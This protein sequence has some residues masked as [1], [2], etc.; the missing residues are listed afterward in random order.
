M[1]ELMRLY[2]TYLGPASHTLLDLGAAGTAWNNL[3]LQG[4]NS[5][6]VIDASTI[7]VTRLFATSIQTVSFAATNMTFNTRLIA[8]GTGFFSSILATS[9]VRF[10][11][12][13]SS[14][15]VTDGDLWNDTRQKTLFTYVNSAKQYIP[16]ILFSSTQIK[17]VSNNATEDSLVGSGIGTNL[18]PANFFTAGKTVRLT[19]SGFYSTQLIPINLNIRIRV[20]GAGGTGGVEVLTTGDQAPA[21][22]LSG[23]FWRTACDLMCQTSG[24]SGTIIGQSAWEHQSTATG[25]PVFWQ[26]VATTAAIVDT[27]TENRIQLSADWAAGVA[28]TDDIRC[29]NLIIESLN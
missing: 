18:I 29:T 7:M 15:T 5:S 4:T 14:S 6:S 20:G 21:G 17:I 11:K 13:N 28:A 3:F 12:V 16:G 19:A 23:M 24:A 9:G 1:T 10:S 26:M 22:N 2:N 27:T 25:S 8:T